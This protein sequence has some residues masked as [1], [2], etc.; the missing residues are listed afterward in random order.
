MKHFTILFLLG[1]GLTTF[2]Q[3]QDTEDQLSNFRNL[4]GSTWEVDGEWK[5]GQKLKQEK[6]F[7]SSLRGRIIKVKTYGTVNMENG[8]YGLRN[9]G[10]RAYNA[11]KKQIEF[12]E[13]DV[14]GGVTVGVIYFKGKDIYYNYTY[15]GMFLTDQWKYVDDD[16]Y[17]Y[18]VGV[19]ED[20]EWTQVFHESRF[21]RKK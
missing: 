2:L 6:V 17:E 9:E 15:Q 1:I 21:V 5:N 4:T 10:I 19:L 13:F 3:A 7:E 18:K 12:I 8:E 11:E 14:F 20:D 16:T